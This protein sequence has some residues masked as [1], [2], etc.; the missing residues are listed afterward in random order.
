MEETERARQYWQSE[1]TRLQ[2]LRDDAAKVQAGMDYI[3]DFLTALQDRLAGIDI[4]PNELRTLPEERRTDIL[5][6]QRKI[7]RALVD[8]V[9]VYASD[10]VAIEGMLD[11]TEAARFELANTTTRW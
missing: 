1:L 2:D 8:K 11:G 3:T 4:P 7:V 9:I 6:A 5:M 10:R